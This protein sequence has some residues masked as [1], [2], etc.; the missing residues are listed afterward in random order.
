LRDYYIFKS[1]RL[2]RNEN[3]IE[4]E[5]SAGEKKSLPINDL[6]SIHLFGEIDLNTKLIVFMNQHG[7]P[8]HFYNYY[9]YYS[10]SFY[11]KEKQ[12]SGFLVVKQVQHYLDLQK[13]LSIAKEFVNSAIHNILTNLEHYEKNGKEVASF[14]NK[15]REEYENLE[16]VS[17]I[18]ELMGIEGRTR[19]IYY[20]SF[21]S[22]LREG[23]DFDRRTKMPPQNM[24]NCLI[25]F[26]NSL[27]YATI[28]TE[29]YHTQLT[30][31]VSYLHE[32]GERRYSL[33]LDISEVFKPIIVDRVIFNLI[34]NRII[35][36]EHFLEELNFCYLKEQG[37][38]IFLS[39]YQK[40]IDTTVN[41]ARLK[42]NISYQRMMRIEC[43]KLVKHL[44]GESSYKGLR[45]K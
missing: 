8:L 14:L 11:P 39:E 1:G 34:N 36:E 20:S 35:K 25:S 3:T 41:N 22:F 43:F 44:L 10:G 40:K 21:S 7:I 31:T 19:G 2:R 24:L 38:R 6:Y 15:I 23:F 26:G 18:A 9:G 17:T 28:L 4:F 33:A 27:L 37:R 42:R 12:V 29:I 13:R 30:P 32:P 16:S 5:N 45:S